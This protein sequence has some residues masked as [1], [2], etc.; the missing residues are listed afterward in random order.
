[1]IPQIIG[2]GLSIAGALG[3]FGGKR[4]NSAAD[5]AMQ[6]ALALIQGQQAGLDKYFKSANTALESQY[7]TFYSQTMQDAIDDIARRGI[8]GSPVAQKR[9]ARITQSL[10]DT[11]A[12]AKSALAGQKVQAEGQINQQLV[13]Y[14]QNLAQMQFQEGMAQAAGQ[15]QLF[16]GIGGIGAALLS[17]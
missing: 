9:Q 12:S 16:S 15:S 2:A 1:M 11:Y 3:A 7:K 8:Y 4:D 14:Y 13:G 6:K 10:A 5:A 17:L